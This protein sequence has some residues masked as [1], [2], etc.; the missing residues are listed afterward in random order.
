MSLPVNI[1]S[2]VYFEWHGER[3]KRS[4]DKVAREVIDSV[5]IDAAAYASELTTRYFNVITGMAADSW[6]SKPAVKRGGT[7]QGEFGSYGVYYVY[8]LNNGTIYITAGHMLQ[9][10]ADWAMKEIPR[11]YAD[12]GGRGE[13]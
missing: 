11:R 12:Q 10:A 4:Q 2:N 6:D 7:W 1:P 5:N 8:Y 13:L 9:Q 3:I